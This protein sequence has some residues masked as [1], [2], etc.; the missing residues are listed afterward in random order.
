MA[1][2][3]ALTANDKSVERAAS[4]YAADREPRISQQWSLSCDIKRFHNPNAAVHGGK[5]NIRLIGFR[6]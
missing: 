2:L 4:L 3:T 1:V 5:L 6:I